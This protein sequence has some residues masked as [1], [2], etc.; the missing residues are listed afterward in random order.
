MIR[1]P[2]RSTLFPYTTLF[3]SLFRLGLAALFAIDDQE[4][5]EERARG[6][7]L[8]QQLRDL[9]LEEG[10]LDLDP[11][12]AETTGQHLGADPAGRAV[13]GLILGGDRDGRARC[14]VVGPREEGHA[15]ARRSP[16]GS[17]ERPRAH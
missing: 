2:P 13:A 3:R 9:G 1:R 17:R 15:R 4:G 10:V 16:P 8:R 12:P 14:V 7:M 6:R 5:V 11:L